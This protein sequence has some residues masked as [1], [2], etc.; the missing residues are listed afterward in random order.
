[1]IRADCLFLGQHEHGQGDLAIS[2]GFIQ[3]EPLIVG[4]LDDSQVEGWW[5]GISGVLIIV[6]GLETATQLLHLTPH[7]WSL[8]MC[9]SK[10][11]FH[12]EGSPSW[13]GINHKICDGRCHVLGFFLYKA[14]G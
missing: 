3:A 14:I 5:A 6:L 9:Y 2:C 7:R 13:V 8:K 1:M 11:P 10:S 12:T 4:C